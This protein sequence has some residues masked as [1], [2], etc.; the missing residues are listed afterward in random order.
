[1][2]L[3]FISR[4]I[5]QNIFTNNWNFYKQKKFR[6]SSIIFVGFS[7]ISLVNGEVL[8]QMNET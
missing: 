7:T 2:I 5:Q 3:A 6:I 4:S 1:M 8:V